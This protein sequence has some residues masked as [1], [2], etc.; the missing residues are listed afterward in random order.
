MLI[1]LDNGSFGLSEKGFYKDI[2]MKKFTLIGLI[3]LASGALALFG[4]KWFQRIRTASDYK[5]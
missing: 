2:S 4:L 5:N 1:F 3:G